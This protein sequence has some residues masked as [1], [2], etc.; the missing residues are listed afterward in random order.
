M[1]DVNDKETAPPPRHRLF[2]WLAMALPTLVG[3]VAVL[4]VLI[5]QERLVVDLKRGVVRFQSPPIY[6]EEPDHQTSGHRYLYD[7]QLG[8]RNIPNWRASTHG[9]TLTINS[10]GLRDREYDYARTPDVPRLLVLGDS[11]VWG[12]GVSDEEI[13]TE[14]LERDLAAAGAPWEVINTGV[15]GWGTDQQYLFFRSEGVRYRPDLV[16]LAFYVNN[17][18]LENSASVTYGMGKP[19]F[20][21]TNLNQPFPP[22]AAG[23]GEQMRWLQNRQPLAITVALA[24]GIRDE[25]RKIGARL[26][27]LK[28]GVF[29]HEENPIATEFSGEFLTTLREAFPDISILDLDAA[30]AER[31]LTHDQIFHGNHDKH[32]NAFGHG[33]VAEL[34][35]RHLLAE[36]LLAGS[37]TPGTL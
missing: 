19:Y 26:V 13:F 27:L 34:L 24:G 23:K 31:G 15:S 18:P 10:M 6:L 21:S 1:V 9:R 33:V 36:G 17:D 14:V 29:G 22:T 8:W 11:F 16:V 20:A 7:A 35:R 37:K 25:C 12:Y 2:R 28:F 32:W 5:Q 4:A 30:F 3:L